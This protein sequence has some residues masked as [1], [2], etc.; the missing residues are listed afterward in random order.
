MTAPVS[1]LPSH[2]VAEAI[3]ASISDEGSRHYVITGRAGSGKTHALTTL[4]SWLPHSV[5]L[6][7][8]LGAEDTGEA[9]LAQLTDG[10]T[11]AGISLD[12]LTVEDI[13]FSAALA[14]VTAALSEHATEVVLLCDDLD[15]WQR[16]ST[17][18]AASRAAEVA[19]AVLNSGCTAVISGSVPDGHPVGF[20]RLFELAPPRAAP[21]R[22][23]DE[24]GVLSDSYAQVVDWIWAGREVAPATLRLL[25][26]AVAG[27]LPRDEWT[28]HLPAL[29]NKTFRLLYKN[30]ETRAAHFAWR[31]LSV[32]RR[33]FDQRLVDELSGRL[34]DSPIALEIVR[35]CL[36]SR[37]PDDKLRLTP[38]LRDVALGAQDPSDRHT[39]EAHF[40]VAEYWGSTFAGR[41]AHFERWHHLGRSGNLEL[42]LSE[43]PL[44]R[45]QLHGLGWWLS[46]QLSDYAGAA[47]V[48]QRSLE[49]DPLD[50]Y[51]HHYKAFNLDIQ[52]V[53]P[54][55]VN[56][57]YTRAIQ[58]QPSRVWWHSRYIRFLIVRDEIAAA[59]DAWAQ[60]LEDLASP[61]ALLGDRDRAVRSIYVDL[62][63]D[64]ARTLLL[65]LELDFAQE[66][67]GC[68]PEQVFER[69]EDFRNLR[70]RLQR[71][72]AA[73][74]D[75]GYVPMWR[76]EPGWQSNAPFEL[77]AALGSA[78]ALRRW[79]EAR[80]DAV[81]GDEALLSAVAFDRARAPED[82]E[83]ITAN[84]PL[85]Q[86]AHDLGIEPQ[87]IRPGT[88]LEIGFYTNGVPTE[89]TVAVLHDPSGRR[90]RLPPIFPAPDRYLRR[91]YG[92]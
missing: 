26:A 77:P 69:S 15:S 47:T 7:A 21:D 62:H 42:A 1:P 18:E 71:L 16:A 10:L 33:G 92:R 75:P 50:S 81:E 13:E 29:A 56:A 24:W 40:D 9:V 28:L 44:F 32:P 31:A 76:M 80:V 8:P 49:V 70:R 89:T 74:T 19:G 34:P 36:L 51:A 14:A 11:H 85:E 38:L 12:D 55:D 41:A 54:Q 78:G 45:E 2:S 23:E 4:A 61:D 67:L 86:L 90:E 46:T 30:Q 43:R 73:G 20:D 60:A 52:G 68:V 17:E 35:R 82:V 37:Y 58:L 53:R 25:V 5:L 64:V 66:V 63:Q 48:F 72:R 87:G 84:V 88:F 22:I 6:Q 3:V 57:H 83:E 27:G 91:R 39:Q 65:A 59:W 79:W